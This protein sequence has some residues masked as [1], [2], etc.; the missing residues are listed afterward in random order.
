MAVPTAGMSKWAVASLVLSIFGLCYGVTAILG[1]IF[2]HIALSE[3][4][5]S[6]NFIQGRGVALAGLILGYLVIGG[7]VIF[8][9]IALMS[10]NSAPPH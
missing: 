7:F 6:N 4:K 1:V 10:M 2:G 3:I 9:G 8:F 5:R